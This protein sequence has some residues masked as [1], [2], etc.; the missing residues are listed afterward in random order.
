VGV[1]GRWQERI[2]LMMQMSGL[3]M[4]VYWGVT[5][6]YNFLL[7]VLVLGALSGVSLA[8][9]FRLFT[10]TRCALGPPALAG[11][12]SVTNGARSGH[13]PPTLRRRPSARCCCLSLACCG[14]TS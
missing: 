14:A 9:Q 6:I 13:A 5:F 2:L 10:Q 7:Y 8:F 11:P 1:G 3:K 4:A 12:S